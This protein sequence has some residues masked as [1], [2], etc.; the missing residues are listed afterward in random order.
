MAPL[1]II[2]PKY[3]LKYWD[4]FFYK[5]IKRSRIGR[6]MAECPVKILNGVRGLVKSLP[7]PHFYRNELFV[8]K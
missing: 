4:M 2:F 8:L 3:S 7:F 6:I 5:N 1:I